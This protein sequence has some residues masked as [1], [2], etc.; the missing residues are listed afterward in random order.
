[1]DALGEGSPE[2]N[3]LPLAVAEISTTIV[4]VMVR[5]MGRVVCWHCG[6]RLIME[7]DHWVCN[8]SIG[9]MIGHFFVVVLLSEWVCCKVGICWWES[10]KLVNS[11]PKVVCACLKFVGLLHSEGM[12]ILTDSRVLIAKL[13]RIYPHWVWLPFCCSSKSTGSKC[14]VGQR[15]WDH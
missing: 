14:Q 1:M 4:E 11:L 15:R 9:S 5:V 3:L 8:D 6:I 12:F 13:S 2:K 10:S 7:T